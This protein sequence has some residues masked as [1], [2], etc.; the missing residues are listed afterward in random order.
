MGV[1]GMSFRARYQGRSSDH[2]EMDPKESWETRAACVG[3]PAIMFSV[4]DYEQ[5]PDDASKLTKW[6]AYEKEKFEQAIKICRSCP[7][8]QE[9]GE[10]ADPEDFKWNVRAGRMPSAFNV[11]SPG[12]PKKSEKRDLNTCPNGHVGHYTMLKR[13]TRACREC[14]RLRSVSQRRRKGIKPLGNSD[15]CRKGHVG[16]MKMEKDG[17]RCQKCRH[18][19]RQ[20][21]AKMSP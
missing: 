13:G 11:R 14:S 21:A 19:Q 10:S 17:R 9:C 5:S 1:V 7:V 2:W 4:V 20:K 16:Y 3:Q 12:R 15:T 6:K 18:L 8:Q